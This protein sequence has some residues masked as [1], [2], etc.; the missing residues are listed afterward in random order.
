MGGLT[1]LHISPRGF[2]FDPFT[3]N[4]VKNFWWTLFK[5]NI[6]YT[7]TFTQIIK[8][9]RNVIKTFYTHSKSERD[10]FLHL[11]CLFGQIIF[12]CVCKLSSGIGRC[13]SAVYL[14]PVWVL[15]NSFLDGPDVRNRFKNSVGYETLISIWF[16]DGLGITYKIAII[17]KANSFI[18]II[19]MY[20]YF[21]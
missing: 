8:L 4:K 20:I 1:P 12:Y 10:S 15:K 17:I 7:T 16:K 13:S 21:F 3:N 19:C 14:N 6:I 5:D 11:S 18:R 9:F 2:L